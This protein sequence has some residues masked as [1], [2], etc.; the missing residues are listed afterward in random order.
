VRDLPENNRTGR[1]QGS[2]LISWQ[3]R[4]RS[5][6]EVPYSSR[7]IG[8][9]IS[10][11]F[12]SSGQPGT[13]IS[14][15]FNKQRRLYP[16]S[17]VLHPP[18]TVSALGITQPEDFKYPNAMSYIEFQVSTVA[19]LAAQRTA[20]RSQ[21][22]CMDPQTIGG[23]QIVVDKV[24]FGNNAIR[25]NVPTTYTVLFDSSTSDA[26]GES[27]EG[28]QTQIAQD[29]TVHVT[30]M[31]DIMAHPNQSPAT[32]VKVSGTL[33]FDLDFFPSPVDDCI[34]QLRFKSFEPGPLPPIPAPW[35]TTAAKVLDLI[36]T[37]LH[38]R[39][40]SKS[41][42][43]GLSSLTT[44]FAKFENAGVSVDGN[45]QRICFRAQIGGSHP[46][47]KYQ[48]MFFYQGNFP[49]RLGNSNW[50][51]HID[52]GLITE[53]IK[54]K[55]NQAI[56]E[57]D[58][59]HLTTFPGC[60]Y[61]NDGG[62]AVFVLDVL[63]IYD[64]PGPIDPSADPKLRLEI[65]VSANN[66]VRLRADYS[67]IVRLIHSIDLVEF[68]VP[69]LSNTIEGFVQIAI[70]AALAEVNKKENAP[71]CKKISTT[72]VE[73][74]QFVQMPP[75][76]AG[77]LS[78]MTTLLAQDDGIAFAGTMQSAD[79][80]PAVISTRVR[81]FKSQVPTISCSSASIALVAAFMDSAS[82]FRILNAAGIVDSSGT[83][84]LFLC[85][86]N[87]V[88]GSDVQGAYPPSCVAVDAGPAGVSFSITIPIP[89]DAFYANPYPLL[90]LVRTTAGTRLLKIAPPPK[91]TKADLDRLAADLLVKIGNCEQL[92]SPWFREHLGY[93]PAWSVD[94]PPESE[95]A[96]LWQVEITGLQRSESAFLLDSQGK[97]LV[98]AAGRL[99]EP[100]TMS[101]LLA[102]AGA[103]ELTL[104]RGSG[105]QPLALE[106]SR[107]EM[108]RGIQVGQQLM[109]Q[110]GSIALGET[111][112]SLYVT[113]FLEGHCVIAVLQNSIRAYDFTNPLRP[114]FVRSWKISDVKGVL[115]WQGALLHYGD[116]G[117]GWIDRDGGEQPHSS[118]CCV[119]PILNAAV[120]GRVL[121][122][123]T[124]EGLEIYSKKLCRIAL[125]R[126]EGAH[127][128]AQTGGKLVIAGAC[129]IYIYD[130]SEPH[131]PRMVSSHE[132]IPIRSLTRPLGAGAGTV[133]AILEDGSARLFQFHGKKLEEM[134]YFS[135]APWF[136]GSVRLNGLLLKPGQN[137]SSIDISKFGGTA[138]I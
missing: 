113:N 65:G 91:V 67:D 108:D 71:Y 34:T 129:G 53:F 33:I 110:V 49:D 54:A 101:A 62:K 100:V 3:R 116:N 130:T 9:P 94:P 41:V 99:N 23:T 40:P 106:V 38:A 112:R 72:M 27:V 18:E 30:T 13:D 50:S 69:A 16:A 137:G 117:F 133:L 134:A 77:T 19:F 124:G 35:Q 118:G 20:L 43:A 76:T 42:P 135:Q 11:D 128:L 52:K 84:P 55:I 56:A 21:Q 90:L 12:S 37:E 80:T 61:S 15:N 87:I 86:W 138:V 92:V 60:N 51:M 83:S 107:M 66:T 105:A 31:S 58:V 45:L 126:I 74:T 114:S 32:I 98:R 121:Y 115:D 63:A 103:K 85:G 1:E 109:E 75:V 68:L 7:P 10:H 64:L 131:R 127:A 26:P 89:S 125:V 96:H 111:C 28:F 39:I 82:G 4:G 2:F 24:E 120:R 25:H 8:V 17:L 81:E 119:N 104:M 132:D 29:V 22:T 47:V 78:I 123:I 70:D 93:N 88:Q 6:P 46:G 102:P 79:L 57:A 97:E 73:C 44:L 48:W 136:T 14:S 122:A 5:A 36:N 59:D 95:V